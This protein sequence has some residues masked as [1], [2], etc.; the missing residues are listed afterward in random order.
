MTLKQSKI[1]L[2]TFILSQF[3]Y[4][5]LVWMFHRR[6]VNYRINRL[7]ERALRITYKD[8]SSSFDELLSKDE[9]FTVHQRNIQT[10]AIELYKV[11]YGM[12][13]KIMDLIFPLNSRATYPG[14]GV[15]KTFNV[16][17]V[18]WGTETLG[19][20]G[21]KI[22]KIVPD[23]MKKFSL[24]KFTKKIRKWKPIDC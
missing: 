14:E 13:P 19:H 18:S 4:C 11:L 16:K 20:L 2:K 24:S 17:T 22:W 3:G 23:D 9:S 7:H 15:F 12:S 10:L 6:K 1:I 8:D 5:P 21:P